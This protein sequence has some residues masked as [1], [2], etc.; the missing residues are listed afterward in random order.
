MRAQNTNLNVIGANDEETKIIETHEY[1]K[2]HTDYNSIQ[3][4][5][6]SLQQKIIN[7]GYIESEINSTRKIND[8]SFQVKFSL[9]NKYESIDISYD[10][11]EIEK[12]LIKT[13]TEKS[14]NKQFSVPLNKLEETLKFINLKIVN[15]GFPFTKIKL[16]ELK[17]K[18][19]KTLTAN[20]IIVKDKKKRRL[21]KVVIKGYEKFPKSF[22]NRF[23]KIKPE[24]TFNIESIKRKM[25]NLNN[26]RFAEQTKNPEVLFSKDSTTLYIY[27]QK[28]QSNTFDGFLGFSTNEET[29]KLD[30]NGYL[31]LELNNNFNY[32]ES[33]R[34]MY[35]S[36][37]SE[38]KN[39]EVNLNLPY[40]FSSPIGTELSLNILKRD[41]TFTTVNQKAS[42]FYQINS[43]N[44]IY[45]GIESVE[46]NNLLDVEINSL[47]LVSDYKSNLYNIKYTYNNRQNFKTIFQLKSSFN[48]EY[49]LGE[50][51][52]KNN[53]EKQNRINL[54]AFHVFQLNN[55]NSFY[56][57]ITGSLINSSS[58]LDNELFRFGGINSIRGFQENSIAAN[59]YIVLNTEYRYQ[60]SKSIYAHSIIDF[61]N[62][63][64]RIIETKENL[65]GFGVGFGILTKAGLLRFNFANGK[66]EEQSFKFSNSKIHLSLVSIF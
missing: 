29:N 16:S 37:E 61:A 48:L 33:F 66:T 30:F 59:Q 36:D 60:L 27:L 39:F 57:R 32:G 53:K 55:K 65:Y 3:N 4:E 7:S 18:D 47:S 15:N 6:D 34:L 43:K 64:N 42:V 40:I 2:N 25:D 46:S 62:F 44:R 1:K 9:N 12:N 24:K 52:T 31:N 50:R 58:Y 26:L 23:L 38:Q 10:N 21:D 28:S 19:S 13:I 49:G 11:T 56:T 17:I 63:E 8:S 51:Q 41:S 22:L 5:I 35:K 45:V 54:D 14:S 20:L